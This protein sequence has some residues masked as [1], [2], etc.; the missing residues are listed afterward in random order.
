MGYSGQQQRFTLALLEGSDAR[1]PTASTCFNTLKMPAYT[2]EEQL[3]DKLLMAITNAEGFDE[4][5]V[6]T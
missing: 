2:S 6:A 5:A 3:K 1:L 4:G